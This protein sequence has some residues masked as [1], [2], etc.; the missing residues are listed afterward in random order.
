MS[1][2]KTDV[3]IFDSIIIFPSIFQ[4]PTK[5]KM[6]ISNDSKKYYERYRSRSLVTEELLPRNLDVTEESLNNTIDPNDESFDD[7]KLR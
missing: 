5:Y 4:K 2:Q 1:T 7:C 6:A 3:I